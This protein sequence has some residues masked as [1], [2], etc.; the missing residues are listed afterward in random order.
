MGHLARTSVLAKEL[1]KFTEVKYIC[2]NYYQEGI[3]FIRQKGFE[4]MEV[5]DV[6]VS[7]LKLEAE[8]LITDHYGIDQEYIEGVRK[9]FPFVGY[10]DD[11]AEKSYKADFILNQNY[12][13]S[14]ECYK[15]SMSCELLLGTRY[16]LVRN[17][18]QGIEPIVIHEKVRNVFVTIGGT[19]TFNLMEGLIEKLYVLPY[20]FYIVIGGG[21]PHKDKVIEK[22]KHYENIHFE[23]MPKM[24]DLAQKCDLAISSCG[25][26]L[27]ELGLVGVPTIGI[28]VADNQRALAIRINQYG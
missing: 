10:I 4:V 18:F 27:Y 9:H 15:N 8:C 11:N 24:S 23:I 16:I 28:T 2:S 14:I 6:Y 20:E 19:D 1:A 22:Y 21:F 17:E 7:L 12:G 25:G 26:T 5:E 13:I 3:A